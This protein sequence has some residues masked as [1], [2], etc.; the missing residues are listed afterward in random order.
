MACGAVD[1]AIGLSHREHPQAG[2]ADR[3]A[4]SQA[5]AG[6]PAGEGGELE[7]NYYSDENACGAG[8]AAR[9][10]ACSEVC[11]ESCG[12][13]SGCE[14]CG[15]A[16]DWAARWPRRREAHTVWALNLTF[17]GLVFLTHPQQS[18]AKVLLPLMW[19]RFSIFSSLKPQTTTTTATHAASKSCLCSVQ[20][21]VL[22]PPPHPHPH[23]P[24]PMSPA[25]SVPGGLAPYPT[26]PGSCEST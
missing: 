20:A 15:A 18:D 16:L 25:A 24:P 9:G 1:L 14:A 7:D 6:S 8:P 2:S 11:G 10:E 26:S 21:N 19:S 22:H 4:P 23:P 12:L 17:V 13:E 5:P 3:P